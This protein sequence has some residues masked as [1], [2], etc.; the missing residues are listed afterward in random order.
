MESIRG[1]SSANSSQP[2]HNK[3]DNTGYKFHGRSYGVAS[4]VG[5]VPN[6]NLDENID[7]KTLLS[8]QYN[9]L[10]Y[11]SSVKCIYNE[12]S[13]LAL[14]PIGVYDTPRKNHGP[15][16]FWANGTLPTGNWTGHATWSIAGNGTVNAIAAA[17]DSTNY[18]YGFVAGHYYQDFNH[19]QCEVKFRPMVFSVKVDTKSQIITVSESNNTA[20]EET[21]DHVPLNKPVAQIAFYTPSY[22]AQM[23]T[24]MYTSSLGRAFQANID[25]VRTRNGHR[26]A[27]IDDRLV[28][29]PEGLEILIDHTFGAV[30][31]AQIMLSNDSQSVDAQAM[32]NVI[33]I[34]EP[35]YIYSISAVSLLIFFMAAMEAIRTRFWKALP[36]F[37]IL[38]L[39]SAI[40]GAAWPGH[41]GR[42]SPPVQKLK[43][44]M[45]MQQTG[46]WEG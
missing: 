15:L 35:T 41:D 24:T 38:D 25:N 40:L 39:K 8:F 42:G 27:T 33:Q 16:G 1:A 21:M 3:L 2:Q 18:M 45:V 36:L 4:A 23:L 13:D 28:G 11:H 26:D 12:T 9:E 10:G 20:T 29:T 14:T 46:K 34:G 6:P 43:N 30:G 44:G 37:N 31:A 22:L 17:T 7:A 5:L 19:I 32:F